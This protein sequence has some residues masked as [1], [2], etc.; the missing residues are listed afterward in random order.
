MT[1]SDNCQDDTQFPDRT[2]TLQKTFY[3]EAELG[4]PQ[5]PFP[6]TCFY[7]KKECELELDDRYFAG[8]SGIHT[9][10][11]VSPSP[12]N[13]FQRSSSQFASGH[14]G[15]DLAW[16]VPPPSAPPSVTIRPYD[17]CPTPRP[18]SPAPSQHARR[19]HYSDPF[20]VGV[21]KFKKR[22]R[23]KPHKSSS[24]TLAS[25]IKNFFHD[26]SKSSHRKSS[27]GDQ[28]PPL[29][30]AD[31]PSNFRFAAVPRRKPSVRKKPIKDTRVYSSD[32][33]LLRQ[34]GFPIEDFLDP[35]L[36]DSHSDNKPE[37]GSTVAVDTPTT[38]ETP[39]PRNH[40]SYLRFVPSLGYREFTSV[41]PS[42]YFSRDAHSTTPQA[43]LPVSSSSRDLFLSLS[44]SPSR[45]CNDTMSSHRVSES[46]DPTSA[47]AAITRQKAEAIKLAREQ[48][49]AVKE[50]CRRA[51]TDVPSYVFEELIGKGAYGRVYK[52]RQ[53][54]SGELVAIKVMDV[55]AMD[56][57]APRDFKDESIKDF[58]HETNV[59]TQ[60]KQAGAKNVNQLVE[61]LSVHS[62]LW[63]VCEY[64]PGGS[65]RTLVSLLLLCLFLRLFFVLA[66]IHSRCVLPATNS[67]KDLSYRLPVNL[68][69]DCVLFTLLASSI[70]MLKVR[71][72]FYCF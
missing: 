59:L 26:S 40:P 43:S 36:S 10:E 68:L 51:N 38:E 53:A 47:V 37:P 65:V 71:S 20:A 25:A 56:Y 70:E 46:L 21:K 2:R 22:P 42:D 3:C 11:S 4:S 58:I 41:G 55:D 64:C 9:G 13:S 28:V 35:D 12:V 31:I 16:P 57:K 62:Q 24:G 7:P 34:S 67:K 23:D 1:W 49:A 33:I 18:P 50:M 72:Y 27:G 6:S 52:G 8:F 61:A 63:L 45:D 39:V 14:K 54:S 29:N 17:S 48:G 32:L 69:R 30:P 60:V 5:R 44:L 66:D 15:R 19:R